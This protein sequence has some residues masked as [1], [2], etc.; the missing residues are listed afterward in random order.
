G[1]AVSGVADAEAAAWPSTLLSRLRNAAGC[2]APDSPPTCNGF[3]QLS[4]DCQYA[5]ASVEA[6]R[7]QPCWLC[8]APFPTSHQSL[9]PSAANSLARIASSKSAKSTWCAYSCWTTPQESFPASSRPASSQIWPG[10]A[11]LAGALA[12]VIVTGPVTMLQL[13]ELA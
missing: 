12:I 5:Q 13:N 2:I 7:S 11:S 3:M 8:A 4:G 1:D 9:P 10:S 6:K